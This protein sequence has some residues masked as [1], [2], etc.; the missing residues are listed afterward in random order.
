VIQALPDGATVGITAGSRGI[1]QIGMILES[2][3]DRLKDLDFD[4]V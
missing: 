2:I 4:P 3:V 1:T